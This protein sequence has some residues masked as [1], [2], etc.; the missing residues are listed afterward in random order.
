MESAN[1]KCG[2]CGTCYTK[3]FTYIVNP[4][5]ILCEVGTIMMTI[6]KMRK[7]RVTGI[8]STC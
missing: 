4:Y 2:L 1:V 3:H 5:N 8:L 6:L 7:L